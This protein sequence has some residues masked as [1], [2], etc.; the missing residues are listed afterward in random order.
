MYDTGPR[1]PDSANFWEMKASKPT[2]HVQK[3][4]WLLTRP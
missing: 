1:L 2:P 4:G 3:K